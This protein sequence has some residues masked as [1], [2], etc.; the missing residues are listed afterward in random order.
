MAYRAIGLRQCVLTAAALAL[1]IGLLGATDSHAHVQAGQ[2]SWAEAEGAPL[3]QEGEDSD[4]EA[5]LP[6]LFAVYIITWA[7]FFAYAFLMSRRQRD[8]HREVEALKM[9]LADKDRNAS[10]S[11]EESA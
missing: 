5:F 4:P 6:F 3:L 11:E 10:K 7:G 9:A 8:L 1:L 2:N